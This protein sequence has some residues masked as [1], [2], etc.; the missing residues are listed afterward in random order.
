MASWH[1]A[2]IKHA[3]FDFS[4]Y[5]KSDNLPYQSAGKGIAMSIR[6]CCHC[7]TQTCEQ[8]DALLPYVLFCPDS[9]VTDLPAIHLHRVITRLLERK[10]RRQQIQG[11]EQDHPD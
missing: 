7:R 10:A 1:T 3:A 8:N 5:T 2:I 4:L 11:N 9:L 6:N